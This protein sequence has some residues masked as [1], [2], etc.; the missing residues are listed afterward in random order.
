MVLSVPLLNKGALS[1]SDRSASMAE[2]LFEFQ[3]LD[4]HLGIS[5]GEQDGT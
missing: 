5:I 3:V 2:L 1:D 4:S